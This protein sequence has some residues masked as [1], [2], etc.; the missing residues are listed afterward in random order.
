MAAEGT[1]SG[2][3]ALASTIAQNKAMMEGELQ[4]TIDGFKA[5]KNS[6]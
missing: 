4:K 1:K 3:D 6:K 2:S 5:Q